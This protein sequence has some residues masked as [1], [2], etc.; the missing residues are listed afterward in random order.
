MQWLSREKVPIQGQEKP[1]S[2]KKK[3]KKKRM[4][5]RVWVPETE[6]PNNVRGRTIG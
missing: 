6:P 4:E 5:K 1:F 2:K 3:K